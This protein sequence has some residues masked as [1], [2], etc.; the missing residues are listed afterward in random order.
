MASVR[1][2]TIGSCIANISVS[3]MS[4]TLSGNAVQ[5]AGRTRAALARTPIFISGVVTNFNVVARC[6]VSVAESSMAW[7]WEV[8]V[9]SGSSVDVVTGVVVEGESFGASSISESSLR[10]AIRNVLSGW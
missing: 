9:A 4:G 8:V 1:R 6:V 7:R 3:K 10:E 2:V 5:A